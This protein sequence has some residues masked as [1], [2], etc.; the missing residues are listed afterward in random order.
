MAPES[1]DDLPYFSG[2]MMAS[3]NSLCLQ[4]VSKFI[5]KSEQ[6]SEIS[7]KS[8][9]KFIENDYKKMTKNWKKKIKITIE[10]N[11]ISEN[12]FSE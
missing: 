9:K 10:K 8:I 1:D 2:Y 6:F 4:F 11:S 12:H 7:P 5:P 3:V